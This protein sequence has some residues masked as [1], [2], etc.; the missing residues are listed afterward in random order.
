MKVA[1]IGN[2][3]NNSN[4][5]A[6]Y[7]LDA[8]IECDV[9][10][11]ANE[12]AHFRPEADNVM[13]ARYGSKTLSW[14]GYGQYFTTSAAQIRADLAPYDFL[15]GSRLSP[16]YCVKAGRILDIFMPTGGDL[17]M[18]PVWNGWKS[19]DVIK[20]LMFSWIQRKA[21]RKVGALYWDASNDEIE[22]TIAPYTGGLKRLKHAI[23]MVYH[24]EYTGPALKHRRGE[25]S[26][27]DQ[28]RAARQD[29]DIFLF[30]HVKH[31][32][33]PSAIAHYGRFHEKGN[34]Q[35]IQAL[36]KY[37]SQAPEKTLR[38]AL[39]EYGTDHAAT[40]ALA[41]Q[42]EVDQYITWFPQMPRKEIMLGIAEADGVIGEITRSWY[43]YGTI[44]EAMVMGRAIIHN[45]DAAAYPD[46]APYP[47]IFANDADSLEQAFQ[48]IAKGLIDLKRLGKD[49]RDWLTDISV[50]NAISDIKKCISLKQGVVDEA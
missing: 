50:A 20:Y 2:M 21:I 24:P 23:P 45:C 11:F 34:D 31:V 12:A 39:F 30:S 25:A 46:Q 29:A 40:R 26:F 15:I 48:G 17:H 14:G 18:V 10:F 1:L 47:M 41:R 6:H 32:W 35:M 33:T 19:R 28:F 4:N 8:G 9:L 36:A 27:L 13:L 16:A 44:L 42:L 5:L 37:Y 38:L 43:S 49:G 3:N 7:L 22:T